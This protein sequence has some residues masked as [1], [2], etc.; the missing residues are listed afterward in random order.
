MERVRRSIRGFRAAALIGGLVAALAAPLDAT[1]GSSASVSPAHALVRLLEGNLRYVAS[2]ARHPDQSEARRIEVANGQSPFA[3]ILTCSDSRV[4]PELL[5]DQGLGSLFVIRLAG[6]VA[7]DACIGS[8]E[9]AVE[10]LGASL[11]LVLGHEKCGAVKAT[12]EGGHAPGR[13]GAITEQIRPALDRTGH[14]GADPLDDAVC[15][16][17]RLVVDRL[18]YAE[19]ILASRVKRGTVEVIGGRYD[20]D[21]GTVEIFH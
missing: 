21:R 17:V 19:P 4:A 10:H 14:R 16:N 3:V 20:L 8:I 6:H 9:Y 12:L 1:L 7:D 11:V 13:I 5:F 2:F 18:R 15:A